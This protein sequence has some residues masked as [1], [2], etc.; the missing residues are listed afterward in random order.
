MDALGVVILLE[1][2]FI[3]VIKT[4]LLSSK[5]VSSVVNRNRSKFGL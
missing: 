4:W 2:S 1:A 3:H 5:I